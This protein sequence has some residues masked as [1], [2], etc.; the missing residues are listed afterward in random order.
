MQTIPTS[1]LTNRAAMSYARRVCNDLATGVTLAES[2]TN[3]NVPGSLIQDL[4][5]ILDSVAAGWFEVPQ[6]PDLSYSKAQ[7]A[8][9]TNLSRCA[10]WLI[11]LEIDAKAFEEV[12]ATRAPAGGKAFG[13]RSLPDY[14][15]DARRASTRLARLPRDHAAGEITLELWAQVLLDTQSVAADLRNQ[16]TCL[17]PS[18]MWDPLHPMPEQLDRLTAFNC[19]HLI[20]SYVSTTRNR[21]VDPFE[22]K[23]LEDVRYRGLSTTEY[24]QRWDAEQ[25]RRIDE[26]QSRWRHR[27]GLIRNL[28]SLLDGATTY[29]QGTLNRRLKQESKGQFRLQRSQLVQGGLVIEVEPNFHIGQ[30]AELESVFLLVNY[31]LAL[32]DGV[33]EC[34]PEFLAYL[35]ACDRA[36]DRIKDLVTPDAAEPR[37]LSRSVDDIDTQAA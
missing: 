22:G 35:E 14:L 19:Q 34:P 30:T 13:V 5:L 23:L 33:E 1:A 17:A 16:M 27:F 36:L 4:S 25:S 31:C 3:R 29:H 12:R 10:P 18:W 8:R 9:L 15:E 28:A 32:A 37:P 7:H 11:R 21:N 24:E 2:L 26:D 20:T 6:G